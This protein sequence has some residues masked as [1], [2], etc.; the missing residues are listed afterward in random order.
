MKKLIT[1]VAL[2]VVTCITNSHS[3]EVK[4]VLLENEAKITPP[5]DIYDKRMAH[6]REQCEREARERTNEE[7]RKEEEKARLFRAYEEETKRKHS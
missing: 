5:E 3:S 4:R 1:V 6:V 7:T 2:F